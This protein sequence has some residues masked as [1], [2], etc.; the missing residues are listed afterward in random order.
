MPFQV[1]KN[2]QPPS[3]ELLLQWTDARGIYRE[4]GISIDSME[5][6]QGWR[7]VAQEDLK[8]GQLLLSMSKKCIF[9]IRTSSLSSIVP[10]SQFKLSHTILPL[11]LCLV[12]EFELERRST[13]YGYLQSLPRTLGV[14]LP[15][16]WD[17][18]NGDEWQDGHEALKWLRGTEA[19]REMIK[20]EKAGMGLKDIQAFYDSAKHWLPLSSP[21]PFSAFAHA[22]CIVS[23]RAFAVDDYHLTALCPFADIFNHSSSPHTCLS[24]DDFVCEQCGSLPQCKHDFANDE[25]LPPRLR[26]LSETEIIKLGEEEDT[27]DMRVE[28]RVEKG[29]EV[30]NTYGQVGDGRLLTEWGFIG[31]EFADHGL[32]WYVEDVKTVMQAPLV[33]SVDW[34]KLFSQLLHWISASKL[35]TFDDSI[36]CP[37]VLSCPNLLNLDQNGRVSVNVFF[38]FWVQIALQEEPTLRTDIPESWTRSIADDIRLV[39][40]NWNDIQTMSVVVSPTDPNRSRLVKVAVLIRRLVENRLQSMYRPETFQTDIIDARDSLDGEKDRRLRLA[41]TLAVNERAL[42]LSALEKWNHYLHVYGQGNGHPHWPHLHTAFDIQHGVYNL[43]T[44][45]QANHNTQTHIYPDT[46]ALPE[47]HVAAFFPQQRSAALHLQTQTLFSFPFRLERRTI[48]RTLLLNHDS[49]KGQARRFSL[50]R[51]SGTKQPATG[52]PPSHHLATT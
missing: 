17:A 21:P 16:F 50:S 6:D 35:D 25:T 1:Y 3:R 12:Y 52:H 18:I 19:A 32:T 39:E 37:P 27:I 46:T 34:E 48:A 49:S 43:S 13:F 24:S 10:E 22:Y 26:H 15:V 5:D 41:M 9:S 42:L 36:L 30:F 11:S 38:V 14:G 23:S 20:K 4:H 33:D 8:I 51:C 40:S 2:H 45:L 44:Q 29:E 7:I 47:S 28:R 31:E